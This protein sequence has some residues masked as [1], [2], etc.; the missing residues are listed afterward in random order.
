MTII[1]TWNI[2]SVRIRLELIDRFITE[3]NPDI[4]LFQ[5]IKC[6]NDDFPDFFS[7]LGYRAII[8]GQKGKYG[9]AILLKNKIE[10][11]IVE[12][13]AD[14]IKKESRTNFIYIKELDLNILNVYTPNGNPIENKEKFDFKISWLR[15]IIKLSS[16]MITCNKNLLIAGDFNVLEET[17]D[18]KNFKNWEKDAL[19]HYRVRK[20]FREILSTGLINIVRLFKRPGSKFS[21]WDY[22]KACWERNDGLL[23]DHFLISPKYVGYVKSINFES[24]Y[25]GLP[26]PS[27]H[28]PVWINLNI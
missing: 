8:N 15:E 5:E 27:D 6:T 28:I 10:Y 3:V 2:N 21:F 9:T 14:I 24:S 20:V 19:G 23:I 1:A 17:S 25:R 11:D 12:I 16:N 18:V 13:K 26:K 22:Q 7:K 4:L